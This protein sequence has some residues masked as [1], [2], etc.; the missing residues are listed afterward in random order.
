MLWKLIAKV[1]AR[2]AVADW[3]IRRAAA[4]PYSDIYNDGVLYMRRGWVFNPYP[5]SGAKPTLLQQLCPYS[6][7]VHHIVKPDD[8]RDHHDHPWNARTIVFRGGYDEVRLERS[9][10]LLWH[11]QDVEIKYQRRAGDTATIGFGEYHTITHIEPGGAYTL[12]I[13]GRYRGTWG[14]LVNGVKVHYKKYLNIGEK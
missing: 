6:I 1:C 4:H 8:A 13:T 10:D 5:Y 7:R 2:P 11:P 9:C 14:F 12:F 3:L